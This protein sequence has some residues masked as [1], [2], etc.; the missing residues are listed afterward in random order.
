MA[1]TF[2]LK[3]NASGIFASRV[4]CFSNIG[5]KNVH[6]LPETYADVAAYSYVRVLVFQK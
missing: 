1:G 6:G 5:A 3:T 2:R 4:I